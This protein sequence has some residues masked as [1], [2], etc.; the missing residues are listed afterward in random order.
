[1][2][3]YASAH[4]LTLD[5]TKQDSDSSADIEISSELSLLVKNRY[6]RPKTHEKVSMGRLKIPTDAQSLTFDAIL[7]NGKDIFTEEQKRT[8]D[9]K[10]NEFANIIKSNF[11]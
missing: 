11:R 5:L 6:E 3:Q 10:S 2:K 8:V 4:A 1:M 7:V 9:F